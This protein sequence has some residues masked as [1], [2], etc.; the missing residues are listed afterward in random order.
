[1]AFYLCDLVPPNPKHE[2][3]MIKKK[4]E[5]SQLTDVFIYLGCHNKMPQTGY[6][7]LLKPQKWIF[8]RSGG[9]KSALGVPARP[10][11]GR[12]LSV[13]RWGLHAVSSLS[14]ESALWCLPLYMGCQPCWIRSHLTSFNFYHHLLLGLI[15]N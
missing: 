6:H 7:K 14:G 10:S 12:A 1:M 11:S 4:S 8:S 3:N 13:C 2:C 5:K 9:R 15:H